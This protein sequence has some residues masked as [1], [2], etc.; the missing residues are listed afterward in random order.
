[1]PFIV[2]T[3]SRAALA[4]FRA[5]L[6]TYEKLGAVARDD[7]H[8]V[9]DTR[10]LAAK[11]PLIR[12]DGINGAVVYT[13]YLTDDARL[14]LANVRDAAGHGAVVAN[15]AAV[16]ELLLTNGR[17]TGARVANTLT[18]GRTVEVHARTI[19]NAAGPWGDQVIRLEDAN[20][21]RRL[22]LTEGIHI[23]LPH[24]RLPIIPNL[25]SVR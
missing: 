25:C 14:T 7:R 18:E 20:A 17:A 21:P 4:K 24:T 13:E 16:T 15:Y 8:E 9:W 6:W 12:R 23:V 11:E 3:R 5:G 22:Q 2:T 1:M 10:E 19:V